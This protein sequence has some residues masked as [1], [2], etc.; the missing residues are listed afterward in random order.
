MSWYESF[1]WGGVKAFLEQSIRNPLS[2]KSKQLLP[3]V[4]ELRG[5]CEQLI[6]KIQGQ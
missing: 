1:I 3:R 2:A 4:I 6:R 5:L